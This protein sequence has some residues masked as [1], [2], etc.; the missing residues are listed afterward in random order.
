MII[1][2]QKTLKK[3]YDSKQLLIKRLLQLPIS[4]K[5]RRRKKRGFKTLL[6]VDKC[7]LKLQLK[8]LLKS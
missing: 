6:C 1:K 3:L 4:C 5:K 2:R 7:K 8:K